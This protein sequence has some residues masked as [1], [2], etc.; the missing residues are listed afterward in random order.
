[1]NS[2]EHLRM[3]RNRHHQP[4]D[5]RPSGPPPAPGL[6]AVDGQDQQAACPVCGSKHMVTGTTKRSTRSVTIFPFWR[7]ER[8]DEETSSYQKC[9]DCGHEWEG[10]ES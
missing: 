1:M 8:W 7:V 3:L 6:R 5:R 9:L 10:G 4:S 2:L